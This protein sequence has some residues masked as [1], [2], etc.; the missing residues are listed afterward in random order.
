M[1]ENG[2]V[3]KALEITVKRSKTDQAGAGTKVLI[4]QDPYLL[5]DPVA[6]A[7]WWMQVREPRATAFFH[8]LTGDF[9]PLAKDTITKEL[10]EDLTRIGVTNVD[11]YSSHSLR[12]M[13]ATQALS[14]GVSRDLVK[15]HG[16]WRSDAVD[17][18]NQP[19][20]AT[21]LQVSKAVRG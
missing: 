14:A 2:K 13:G 12:K 3:V 6:W 17:V 1:L 21:M 20:A 9:A 11:D 7:E 18:Y 16:R 10:R 8:K 15:R 5:V 4:A 19:S